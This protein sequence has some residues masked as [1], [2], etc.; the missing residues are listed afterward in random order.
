MTTLLAFINNTIAAAAVLIE[1]KAAAAVSCF[2]VFS[3]R[4]PASIPGSEGRLALG[5]AP[6]AAMRC[7]IHA[8]ALTWDPACPI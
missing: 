7:W 3:L 1:I 6:V 8:A 2:D 4:E 5:N